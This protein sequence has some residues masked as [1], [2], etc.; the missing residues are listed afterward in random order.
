MFLWIGLNAHLFVGPGIKPSVQTRPL[1]MGVC[2]LRKFLTQV[3]NPVFARY[4]A[5]LVLLEGSRF[6]VR[7][8]PF[9]CNRSKVPLALRE[10]IRAI[11]FERLRFN[12]GLGEPPTWTI[13]IDDMTVPIILVIFVI[14][15]VH[16]GDNH[17]AALC[18][19]AGKLLDQ[20]KAS[21][22]P[23]FCGYFDHDAMLDATA[24]AIR[25]RRQ[26]GR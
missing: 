26:I 14:R 21:L 17:Q 11:A 23:E 2:E 16:D 3:W 1:Q 6:A 20:L 13:I 25:E 22:G 5:D 10:M 9:R 4:F 15:R 12:I 7:S 8:V 19:T 18:Q 24:S